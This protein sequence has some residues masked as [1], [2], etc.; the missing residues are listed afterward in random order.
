MKK[1]ILLVA[2]LI[3]ATTFAQKEE[4][5]V[6]KK[7]YDKD[8]PSE[9][10]IESYK[11]ALKTI[12]T[13]TLSEE[14][15]V[16][17]N[18]YIGMT[19]LVEIASLGDAATP[20]N[21]LKKFNT[22]SFE[23]FST[24]VKETLAYEKSIGKSTYTKDINENLSW[25]VPLIEASAY[26]FNST[27]DYKSASAAFYN[28]YTLNN[29]LGANL[30]NAAILAVQAE[31][32]Q[33][34]LKLYEEYRDSDY[35]E[36]GIVYYAI[37]V[38]TEKEESF[39]TNAGRKYKIDIKNHTNP[40]DAKVSG[41]ADILKIIAVLNI[42]LNDIDAAKLAY[43]SAVKESPNDFELLIEEANFYYNQ[44]DTE[45]YTLLVKE[46]IKKDPTNAV[47]YFNLGYL[48]LSNEN[49]LV[50]ELNKNTN[51]PEIYDEL[52]VKRKEMYM[53]AL[54]YFEESHKLDPTKADTI[55]LL[56]YIYNAVGMK[57]KAEKL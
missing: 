40:R 37:N 4:L 6:L 33:T 49:D 30:L 43:K 35:L 27:E 45:T 51:N 39:S 8:K 56:K 20:Q 28:S 11:E 38:L 52:L 13:L 12:E 1:V 44:K 18:F 42:Q 57:E 24:A 47:L 46:I 36:N 31:D 23:L 21:Q 25:L 32:Y 53:S 50:K 14:E 29:Q 15:K 55:E 22:E 10:H 26:E 7:I 19:P 2:I 48:A 5:K 3:T 41:R 9:A 17:A 16:Y 54:P 34:G